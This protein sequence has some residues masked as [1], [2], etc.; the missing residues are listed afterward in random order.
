MKILIVN[1]IYSPYKVGGAEVSVQLLA[2]ELVKKGHMVRVVTLHDDN[3][4][5]SASI[6][7]VDVSYLPLKNIYWPF[8]NEAGK[9]T[10]FQKIIWHLVDNYNPLM[11]KSFGRELDD[12][13]P[14]VVHTNNICGFSV[15][16]W[17]EVKKR[18]IKLIHTS[19]DYYLLHPNS[20]LYS[21]SGNIATSSLPVKFWS[22]IKRLAS[23]NIDSYVGISDFIKTFHIENGFF[24]ESE[25]YFIYNAVN[26]PIFTGKESSITRFGFIGRLTRD[27]GFDDYCAYA[28]RNPG[29][30]YY[31]AGRFSNDTEGKELKKKASDSNIKLLG[32]VTVESFLSRIDIAFLPVKWQ[33]PFGRVIVECVLANKVVMTNSVG[34]I[35]ELK[36]LLPNIYFIG[37]EIAGI[38]PKEI[39]EVTER[40]IAM[41][42]QGTITS[43]YLMVYRQ[44]FNNEDVPEV[45]ENTL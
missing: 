2:E 36:N 31:A 4:K 14:D 27:K 13:R 44:Q 29:S 1:T 33:E 20:T 10:A 7:G 25:N 40:Q 45:M 42:S 26:K 19:R 9:K 5:K 11:A 43:N 12:F 17:K 24:S 39:V 35:T 8:D 37:K 34:G 3:I 41:F 18:K 21:D 38:S 22:F 32:F 16:I 23:S 30:I 15:A 28:K 6:N